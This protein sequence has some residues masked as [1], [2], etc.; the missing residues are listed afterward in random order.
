MKTVDIKKK[1]ID[2]IHLSKNKN[3]LMELYQFLNLENS[4]QQ[5]YVLND[6]QNFA[7]AEAR[8]QVSN[9]D[10]LSMEDA[11]NQVDEWFRK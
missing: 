11:N 9:G 7:I 5:I 3:L 2:E 8:Q 4:A 6:D 10:Y 1:L